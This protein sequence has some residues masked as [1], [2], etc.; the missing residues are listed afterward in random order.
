[1]VPNRIKELREAK[2]W[3]QW[4]LAHRAQL[5]PARISQYE[6]G[7]RVPPLYA[8][9]AIAMALDATLDELFPREEVP[10]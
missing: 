4:E 1:M 3:T 8:A 5:W 7:K 9:Q 6:N 2:G 10:A